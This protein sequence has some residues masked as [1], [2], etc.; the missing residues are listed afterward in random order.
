MRQYIVMWIQVNT[1]PAIPLF[2]SASCKHW[3]C[4]CSFSCTSLLTLSPTTDLP[5]KIPYM[6]F[7]LQFSALVFQTDVHRVVH[8]V[9]RVV[10]GAVRGIDGG[11]A[12]MDYPSPT[13]RSI[14]Y[15]PAPTV[16]TPMA[17]AALSQAGA[18]RSM[19]I[20]AATTTIARRS[21]IP[22]T[23]RIVI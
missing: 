11:R 17:R 5:R 3:R 12:R 20:A 23:R 2:A 14:R 15:I 10:S 18:R 22:V 4:F 8:A 9:Q 7:F 13:A 19:L 21:M 1:P 16:N 6:T